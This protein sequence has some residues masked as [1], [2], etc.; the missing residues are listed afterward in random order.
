M[1]KKQCRLSLKRPGH[2]SRKRK[3]HGNRYSDEVGT[4]FASTSA[5]KLKTSRDDSFDVCCDDSV[6]YCFIQFFL[7]FSALQ[8]IVKCKQCNSSIK[9]F[10]YGQRG[11][12]FKIKIQ[13]LCEDRVIDSCKMID[14]A[15][16]INRRF[17]YVMRLLGVGLRGIQIFCGLMDMGRGLN[18]TAYYQ[19]IQSIQESVN[20]V[21]DLVTN[22]AVQEEK[23]LNVQ[24][25]YPENELSVSGDGSWSMEKHSVRYA[26]YIGDGDTKTFRSLLQAAPYGDDFLVRRKECVLHVKKR[27]YRR[28]KE[29]KKQ[30]M[31]KKKA[32]KQQEGEDVK[33]KS[34]SKSKRKSTESKT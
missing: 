2:H 22:K 31:L 33:T 9:F 34:K 1:D 24:A 20:T 28:A 8:N 26:S 13:C 11:L 23:D 4:S 25:G 14:N 21:Y 18:I 7:V 27:F 17:A 30:L 15:Y 19:V 10:K 5:E 3:F 12:G 29:A 16:E 6:S 32:R